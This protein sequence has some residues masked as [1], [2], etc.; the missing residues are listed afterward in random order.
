MKQITT[1][2]AKAAPCGLT[3]ETMW[4]KTAPSL[5]YVNFCLVPTHAWEKNEIGLDASFPVF[6][7]WNHCKRKSSSNFPTPQT[8]QP[9]GATVSIPIGIT[10]LR[11]SCDLPTIQR[12]PY[13]FLLGWWVWIQIC[14]LNSLVVLGYGCRSMIN[15]NSSGGRMATRKCLHQWIVKANCILE[16]K[17]QKWL[18]C[19]MYEFEAWIRGWSQD[20][21]AF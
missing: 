17:Q 4:A 8:W 14:L 7:L 1:L 18:D 16:A 15:A 19:S 2:W 3:E 6:L 13:C 10:I 21:Q 9:K 5:L 11:F 12:R 20:G